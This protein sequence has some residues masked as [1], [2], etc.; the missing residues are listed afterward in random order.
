ME[1]DLQWR[2][3]IEARVAAAAANAKEEAKSNETD[4]E[5]LG[6]AEAYEEKDDEEIYF[7]PENNNVIFSSAFDGWAFS[8]GQFAA[9]YEKKIGIK[10]SILQKCL[11]GDFYLDPKSKR[12]LG[13]K[14]LK[15]RNLKPMFVQLVLD[16]IWAVYEATMGGNNGKGD[17][18]LLEKIT[19][20][21]SITIPPHILRSRDPRALMTTVFAS[22]VP[23]STALLVTVIDR[24]P[25]PPAAQATRMPTLITQSPGAEHVSDEIQKSMTLFKTSREDPVV[26]FVSKMVSIPA[27]EL[28]QNKRKAGTQMSPEE[29]REMAKRKRAEIA[30][31]Q[32][33]AAGAANGLNDLTSALS[34]A[35]IGEEEES[36]PEPEEPE[37]DPEQL[38]GFARLY[39]GTL[40]V[41]DSIYVL[42]P[43]FT[44]A[45]PHKSPEPKKVTVT[46]L[47]LLMGR[48][49]EA[50]ESVPAGVV[51]GIGGLEGA[52]L[53]SGTLCS[54]LEGSIN[55]AG[56]AMG[57][58]PIVR[59]ALEPVNPYDLDKMIHGM[60]LLEQSD[61]CAVYEQL[62]SG[63]H[64]ILTAGEL[65][66]ERCLKDLQERFA[67][68]EIQPGEPIVPY[69]ETIVSATEMAELKNKEL[70]RGTAIGT[71][72]SKQ[73]S[74]R[75]R[76]RPLPAP[77]TQFLIDNHDAIRHLYAQQKADEEA[78]KSK[79]AEEDEE[80]DTDSDTDDEH[81]RPSA[82]TA[83]DH[84]DTDRPTSETMTLSDLRRGLK[85]ALDAAEISRDAKTTWTSAVDRITAFGPRRTGPNLLI[86]ST[87]SRLFGRFLDEDSDASHAHAAKDAEPNGS[88]RPADFVDRITY[89]FQL[90]T[91]QGPLCHEPVQGIAVFLEDVS[92]VAADASHQ[93]KD[94]DTE[95]QNFDLG[96][97]TGE[98]IKTVRSAI[99]TGFMTWS[100]R[101]LLAMYTCEIQ[102]APEVLGRVYPTITRRRGR[103]LSEE[104]KEGT[105]FFTITAVL[106][107]ATSFGFGD[108]IRKKTSG[109]AQPQLRFAGFE[110]L[111]EDPMW[112]PF[113]E[114]ELEDLGEKADRENV[115]KGFVDGVRRRKGLLVMGGKRE[116]AEKARTLKR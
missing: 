76:V 36:Q 85:S 72:T 101:I 15:G 61:P 6:D 7:A 93:Q 33:D 12:V 27:S 74:V 17:P 10:R 49:L 78:V 46:S 88:I 92:V 57:A 52:V 1:E 47:F 50:L 44:P 32:A 14:H 69:R 84:I 25:S 98:I 21:L 80:E 96:R 102:A 115:A 13:S 95:P 24:L 4:P 68:C 43:K 111:D 19:K 94:G 37:E 28:P 104:L 71:T 110:M 54:Q 58:D 39:S 114:E 99:R 112:V 20:A 113:T 105:P 31:A 97:L 108:D 38:I 73:A 106:P 8:V 64:V 107:V 91:A 83:T 103:I 63:E 48:S 2:E 87:A 35:A 53:K 34:E 62:D 42:P 30:K 70:P 109:G 82:N 29:A 116:G 18:A 5:T 79:P 9:L 60:K 77:L 67:R 59:V 26:A 56:V 66:L 23:L 86:D 16:N 40:K 100:P 41:G 89:A 65:H 90:A 22:W 55:L 3:K 45:D 11:W 81:P 75:L 51:F